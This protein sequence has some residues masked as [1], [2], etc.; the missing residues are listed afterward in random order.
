MRSCHGHPSGVASSTHCRPGYPLS[1]C[2]GT[3]YSVSLTGPGL[4]KRAHTVSHPAPA[5]AT[6]FANSTDTR[7]S[8]DHSVQ[9]LMLSAVSL[10]DCNVPAAMFGQGTGCT[11]H[12]PHSPSGSQPPG[13]PPG[14]SPR[15]H[16]RGDAGLPLRVPNGEA[17][18]A[19]S[20]VSK[21]TLFGGKHGCN[22]LRKL[23][24]IGSSTRSVHITEYA[25]SMM[26]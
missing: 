1:S 25:S 10:H 17:L 18:C 11:P 2:P 23:R 19:V 4:G 20:S 8:M 26:I 3:R 5:S 7:R 15:D 24:T 16:A 14:S 6:Q 21:I 9:G 22:S 12:N 13:S